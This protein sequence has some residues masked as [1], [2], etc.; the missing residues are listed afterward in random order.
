MWKRLHFK[1]CSA[2]AGATVVSN[3]MISLSSK[4]S[5]EKESQARHRMRKDIETALPYFKE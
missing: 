2:C 5:I 3:T 1:K 4:D